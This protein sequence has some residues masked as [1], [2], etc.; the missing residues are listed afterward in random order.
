M[1]GWSK[2]NIVIISELEAP[3]DFICVWKKEYS[4]PIHTHGVNKSNSYSEKLFI[5]EK[6]FKVLS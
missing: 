6:Y 2:E 1:R 4:I 3:E 5:H